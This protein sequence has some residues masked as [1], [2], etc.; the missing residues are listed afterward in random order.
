LRRRILHGARRLGYLHLISITT[1][2]RLSGHDG[3][4]H[5]RTHNDQ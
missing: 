4:E 5:C 3:D 2:G 1:R